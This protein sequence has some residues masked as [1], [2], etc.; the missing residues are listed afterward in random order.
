MQE[1]IAKDDLREESSRQLFAA[2]EECCKD[3]SFSLSN[4]LI[5]LESDELKSLLVKSADV[6]KDSVEE[7]AEESIRYLKNKVLENKKAGI[8]ERIAVLSQSSLPEDKAE[9][10][11]LL[12]QKMEV[13]SKIH[14]MKG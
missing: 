5:C 14:N 6:H 13:D 10:E 11:Y 9:L 3:N 4:I 12:K 2:M 8:K 1:V 7:S